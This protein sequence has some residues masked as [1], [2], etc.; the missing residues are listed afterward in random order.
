MPM[1]LIA[2]HTTFGE[3]VN[4]A[5]IHTVI[6]PVAHSGN[7]ATVAID[8][9]DTLAFAEAIRHIDT[10]VGYDLATLAR[11]SFPAF[12][13]SIALDPALL[14]PKWA[15]RGGPRAAR[16][17]L[18][19][20]S[21]DDRTEADRQIVANLVGTT[22]ADARELLLELT[23]GDDA[24]LGLTD[25]VWHVVST[26][27]AWLELGRYLLADD[28]TMFAG[29]A[30]TSSTITIRGCGYHT[31]SGGEPKST[32]SNYAIPNPFETASRRPW[33]LSPH[34][35]NTSSRARITMGRTGLAAFSGRSS[36]PPIVMA[37]ASFGRASISSCRSWP[38]RR[39]KSSSTPSPSG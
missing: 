27:D 4:S 19:L 13:R 9:V 20:S 23:I 16:A 15:E 2:R 12:R 5:T 33:Q 30:E 37:A 6:V 38:K 3:S 17:A 36:M 7:G 25:G 1:I 8:P 24:L 34:S 35:V 28:V 11:R 39:R 32:A 29:H 14:R 31:T 21:W 26:V 18:L 10:S 22:Y